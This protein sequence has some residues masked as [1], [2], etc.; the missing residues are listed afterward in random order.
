MGVY[1][2]HLEALLMTITSGN[3]IGH[4]FRKLKF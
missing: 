3:D 1:F 4:L 2:F